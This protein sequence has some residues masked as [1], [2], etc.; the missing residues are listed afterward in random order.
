MRNSIGNSLIL[1]IFGESHG[2]MIGAT[3]DG[4]P[5]GIK[6]EC[7]NIKKML[8]KRRPL[9]LIDTSRHEEDDFNIVSGVYN[10]Y[11]NGNPLTILIKN[12]DVKSRDYEKNANLP[13][14]SHAD[15]PAHIKYHGYEDFRGG[16]HFS[17]RITAGIV[18][19]GAICLNILQNKNILVAS[20]ILQCGNI[21]DQPF[22]DFDDE[23]MMLDKKAFPTILDVE[24][25]MTN[26]ILKVKEEKDSIGGIIETAVTGLEVGLGE[27]WFDSVESV[28]AKAL[29]AIG[30]VKGLEFG[31][32]FNF[33]TMKG[34]TANDQFSLKDDKIITTTNH[35][36]G[37]NGGLTNG[38]PVVMRLAIKPTP[39]IGQ[40][41]DS[42]N[43]A[44]HKMEKLTITGR[45]D[46]AIIRRICPVINSMV[47]ITLCD[48][49]ASAHGSDYL[50]DK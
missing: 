8:T 2:E 14:P 27:P 5:A 37:I 17:G 4:L 13:R 50:L 35:N 20:H 48:I 40:I 36:G 31:S 11:T 6:V 23:M 10:G 25:Q 47:A 7:E 21:C 26:A 34:S 39:S 49:L 46:P 44:T 22:K 28:L 16:G 30:G 19:I 38:M 15:Y 43:L 33:A 1:T 9:A 41:Q 32:G 29:F 12:Q 24:E 42:I 45:H 18:A 3:L